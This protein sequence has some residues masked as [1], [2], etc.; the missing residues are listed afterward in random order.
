[1]LEMQKIM[2]TVQQKGFLKPKNSRRETGSSRYCRPVE[3]KKKHAG[4]GPNY[5]VYSTKNAAKTVLS[6]CTVQ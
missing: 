2:C 6:R 5:N 1:M 3:Q 4:N